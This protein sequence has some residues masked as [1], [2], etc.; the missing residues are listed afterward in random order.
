M[1]T[2]SQF[3]ISNEL[4]HFVGR[5][6]EN[7]EAQ[8]MLF[9]SILKSERLSNS[10][11]NAKKPEGYKQIDIDGG[12]KI[13]QDEMF[14]PQMVCFCDIPFEPLDQLKIHISKYGRFGIAFNK[15]F[16]VRKGGSPV[17]YIPIQ[18]KVSSIIN[19][20]EYFDKKLDWF[21]NY[22]LSE[23]ENERA[24]LKDMIT[25]I[26]DFLS[27]HFFSYVKFFDQSLPDNDPKNYY[28]EREWR[29]L[30][31]LYFNI[32]DITTIFVPRDYEKQFSIDYPEYKDK[33]KV[34][35]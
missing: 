31:N 4:I 23:I 6:C 14:I 17:Y 35:T 16:I 9:L 22:F 11:Q 10:K 21:F 19:K 15:D 33:V 18:S 26:D 3:Y 30:G 20:G 29:I 27:Y 5:N 12:A 2:F 25:E 7:L 8:Y 24:E 34:L 32:S 1:N 13:S 28:F